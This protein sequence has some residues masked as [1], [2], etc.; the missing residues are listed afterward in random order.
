[1]TELA[2]LLDPDALDRAE[3]PRGRVT[4]VIRP[5]WLAAGDAI[6]IALPR[7]LVCARCEGGGCDGCSRSGAVRVSV[8]DPRI[9]IG[10]P[11]NGRA[12]L[13]LRL[14]RPL[15]A[16]AGLEQLA[17]EVRT[18]DAP[19][20]GCARIGGAAPIQRPRWTLLAVALAAAALASA[21]AAG[22]R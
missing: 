5:E 16:T 19:T 22:L 10:L 6:E 20:A 14:V 7:R 21:L 12:P 11:R 15:G 18:G 1:M 4:V 8:E 3:G 2:R 13:L 9:R 17:V